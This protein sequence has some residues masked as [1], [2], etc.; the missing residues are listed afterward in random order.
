MEP[1]EQVDA[2]LSHHGIKGMKWGVKKKKNSVEAAS[3]DA[4]IKAMSDNELRQKINRIQMEKQYKSLTAPSV[5]PGRK[6]AQDILLNT[7]KQQ[8]SQVASRYAAQTIQD[9]IKK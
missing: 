3:R 6:F 8:L 2:F 7:A 1:N 9:L 4:K 5:S